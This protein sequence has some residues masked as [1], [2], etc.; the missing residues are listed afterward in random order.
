MRKLAIEDM[1]GC[2]MV[3]VKDPESKWPPRPPTT[4]MRMD[5]QIVKGLKHCAIDEGVTM[6]ELVERLLRE[7][8]T[9]KGYL[10]RDKK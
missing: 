6:G 4:G 2:P 10:D 5:G 1:R 3:K 7:Y 9:R 8:L